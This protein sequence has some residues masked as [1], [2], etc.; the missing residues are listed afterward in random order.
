MNCENALPSRA[1]GSGAMAAGKAIGFG[2]AMG[3]AWMFI[4]SVRVTGL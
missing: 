2:S 1:D 3:A 4:V